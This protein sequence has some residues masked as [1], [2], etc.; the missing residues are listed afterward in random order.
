MQMYLIAI[1]LWNNRG[2]TRNGTASDPPLRAHAYG[3][4]T[5]V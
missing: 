2:A 3:E 5:E 1:K 4:R